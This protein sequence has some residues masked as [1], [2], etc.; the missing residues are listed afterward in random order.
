MSVLLLSYFGTRLA[1]E[2]FIAEVMAAISE[3]L[4]AL[5]PRKLQVSN[6]QL[7]SPENEDHIQSSQIELP[8]FLYAD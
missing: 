7:G 1:L 5:I 2:R 4:G 6:E 8:L 3:T